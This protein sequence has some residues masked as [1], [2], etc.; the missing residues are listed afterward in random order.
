M[1]EIVQLFEDDEDDA[2]DEVEEAQRFLNELIER[3]DAAL[4]S[5]VWTPEF[6]ETLTEAEKGAHAA[7][8]ALWQGSE[9]GTFCTCEVCITRTVLQA[10]MPT[11]TKHLETVVPEGR[12]QD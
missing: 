4:S 12:P 5:R 8:G 9:D 3:A 10:V 11:I 1:S 6:W 2:G 7:L